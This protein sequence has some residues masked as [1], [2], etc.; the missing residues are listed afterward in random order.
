MARQETTDEN[1]GR[2]KQIRLAYTMTKRVDP[3]IGL[4]TAGI[5]I[6]TFAVLLIVGFAIGHPIYLGILGFVLG[7]LG[8]VIIFGRRAEKAA[9]GQMEGQPGAAA[10]VLNNIKRGWSVTPVVAATRQQDAIHRAVGRPGIV[11][12]AEGNVNRLRPMLAEEKRKMNRVVGNVPV[13]DIIVGDGE[14]QIPLKKLH[15]HLTKMPRT[16]PASQVTQINDRL[17]AL[18][19][20]MSNAPI[21]K[22]PMPKGARMPKGR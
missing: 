17:R 7:L 13:I 12:V 19:D 8:A 21:P 15:M 3:K 5:G 11:L 2:L 4:I 22:G 16:L 14:G 9:F 20:L 1:P 18:G 10:A 6:G